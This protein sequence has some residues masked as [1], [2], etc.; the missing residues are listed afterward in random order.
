MVVDYR[1]YR[2]SYE[3]GTAAEN[4]TTGHPSAV[5]VDP[6][7]RLVFWPVPDGDYRLGG[8]WR[9]APQEFTADS[10]EPLVR[11]E[12]HQTLVSAGALWLHRHDEAPANT[13]FTAETDFD[14]DLQDLRRRYLYG[15]RVIVGAAPIGPSGV[16]SARGTRVF[17]P[18]GNVDDAHG[19]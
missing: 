10:E 8:T 1:G 14:A 16:N 18:F 2:G 19:R 6:Q 5:A 3:I 13:L 4:P 15:S 12:H 11:A 7:D 9:R 17:F